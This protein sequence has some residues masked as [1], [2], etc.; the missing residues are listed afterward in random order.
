MERL[1]EQ[2]AKGETM[3]N[4]TTQLVN[5]SFSITLRDADLLRDIEYYLG[6]NRSQYIRSLI[7]ANRA[8]AEEAIKKRKQEVQ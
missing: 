1:L 5:R 7:N 4:E 3:S 8:K 2:L 6:M